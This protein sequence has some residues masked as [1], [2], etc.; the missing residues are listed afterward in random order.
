MQDCDALDTAEVSRLLALELTTRDAAAEVALRCQGLQV[1]VVVQPTASA[2]L[3]LDVDLRETRADARARV[4][5]LAIAELVETSR[6]EPGARPAPP[7]EPAAPAPALRLGL[8]LSAGAARLLRPAA[9]GPLFGLGLSGRRAALSLD[10]DVAL[11]L[12]RVS[13][14][15]AEVHA[16]LLSVS[17][18]AGWHVAIERL[19]LGLE[20]GL[21]GA[22]VQLTAAARSAGVRGTSFSGVTLLPLARATLAVQ[23]SQA[24][25]ARLGVEAGY[26]A[27]PLSGLDADGQDL[28]ALRGL[29]LAATLA[30]VLWLDG[31]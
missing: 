23:L 15:Q 18:A 26:V 24:F 28:V 7:Q 1:S 9:I 13:L 16:R 22:S 5:A 31:L 12:A 30:A 4:L 19:D 3:A 2:P 20:L 29:R 21:R 27:R 11:E 25:A 14:D 10:A 17:V 8:S 6:L